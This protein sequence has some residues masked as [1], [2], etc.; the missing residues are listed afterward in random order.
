MTRVVVH[1]YYRSVNDSVK[2][3]VDLAE[4]ASMASDVAVQEYAERTKS[5]A[6]AAG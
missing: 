2:P 5:G 6:E 4:V 1:V 3:E